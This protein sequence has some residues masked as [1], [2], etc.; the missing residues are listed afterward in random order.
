MWNSLVNLTL[1]TGT[2]V[3][4]VIYRLEYLRSGNSVTIALQSH[5]L[6]LVVLVDLCQVGDIGTPQLKWKNEYGKMK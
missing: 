2:G 1:N 4:T 5:L 3:E 6:D